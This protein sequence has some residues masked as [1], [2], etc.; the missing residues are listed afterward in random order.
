[1]YN[2]LRTFNVY[3]LHNRHCMYSMYSMLN[4]YNMYR[5]YNKHSIDTGIDRAID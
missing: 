2:L 1:M 5:L 3:I 4:R